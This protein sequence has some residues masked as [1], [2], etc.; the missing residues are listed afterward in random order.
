V[1]ASAGS[2]AYLVDHNLQV[3]HATDTSS[4]LIGGTS[5]R[6]PLD[7]PTPMTDAVRT[8]RPVWIESLAESSAAYPQVARQTGACAAVPLLSGAQVIGALGLTFATTRQFQAA[9]REMLLL[10]ASQCGQALER[11]YLYE[12]ERA[13]HATS[14]AAVRARD[15]FLSIAAHE[16][17]TPVTAI[18]LGAQLMSQRAAARDLDAG[19]LQKS[20]RQL[21]IGADRLARLTEDLLDVARLQ[22]GR[23]QVRPDPMDL[24]EVIRRL[25]GIY[26]DRLTESQRL[27]LEGETLQ[28]ACPLVADSMRLEQVL[29]NLLDNAIK[30]SPQG[31]TIRI[32]IEAAANGWLVK[33]QDEGLGLPAG[34]EE[35]I[36]QPFGRAANAAASYIQGLG[37]GLYISRQIVEGHGGR[38]WAESHGEGRGTRFNMWLPLVLAAGASGR[39]SVVSGG[40]S[41]SNAPPRRTL[42][43]A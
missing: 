32:C 2:V 13:A 26:H 16:L 21:T 27:V 35:T 25:A 29:A 42:P 28:G 41:T 7:T 20:V 15:E 18:K 4:E 14:Q 40:S 11:A 36:F 3:V 33:V 39:G 43:A 6:F 1:R 12:G 10:L 8:G 23:L 22:T 9:D 19:T 24:A 37:L 38:L 17:K 5:M 31:G 34:S 30:Y